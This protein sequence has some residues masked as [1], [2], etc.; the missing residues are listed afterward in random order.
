MLRANLKKASPVGKASAGFP[1]EGFFGEAG[2][3]VLQVT[4]IFVIMRI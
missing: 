1:K 2:R 3:Y 4:V